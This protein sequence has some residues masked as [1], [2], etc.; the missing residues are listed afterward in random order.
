VSRKGHP[1]DSRM[2]LI[3]LTAAGIEM[4]RKLA[5]IA[6]ERQKRPLS[7]LSQQEAFRVIEIL[8]RNANDLLI[9]P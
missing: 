5:P 9:N 8:E 3:S 6:W 7:G 2:P 1:T 4:I